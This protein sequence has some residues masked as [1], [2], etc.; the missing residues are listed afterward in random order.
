MQHIPVTGSV[1]PAL[2][3][4]RPTYTFRMSFVLHHINLNSILLCFMKS[5]NFSSF[6][7]SAKGSG[8]CWLKDKVG[9]SWLLWVWRAAAALR[10]SSMLLLVS[11]EVDYPS[12]LV[13]HG[14]SL[15]GV[16][17]CNPEPMKS[18]RCLELC[19]VGSSPASQL[20]A[21]LT[22]WSSWWSCRIF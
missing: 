10:A 4:R 13:R 18:E 8:C 20:R 14:L 6:S 15:S 21:V 16:K 17:N 12:I 11:F 7:C 1:F 19:C 3:N 5:K 2:N 9:L 22:P